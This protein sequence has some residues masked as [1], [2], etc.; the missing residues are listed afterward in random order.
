M[1]KQTI[2]T[3]I[4]RL[5][6]SADGKPPGQERF[7]KTTGIRMSEW[8]P[9]LWLRWGEALQE[10]GFSPN[11]LTA[12]FDERRVLECYIGLIRQLGRVPV[13]GELKRQAKSD[14]TFPSHNVFSRFGGKGELLEKVR[15]FCS[16]DSGFDDVVAVLPPRPSEPA[17]SLRT[18]AS[19]Q[20]YVYMMRSG[21]RYKIGF[22]NSPVRRHRE[23]KLE[24]P[25]PTQLVHS[26][27]TD[28]PKGIEAYWHRRFEAKR[29]RDTE[30]FELDATDVASFKRRRYQ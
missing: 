8:Y 4:R 17:E 11:R 10:A 12:A 9:H 30:F 27:E 2:L 18:R 23:V 6:E 28:D 3:E 5:A 15:E 1:D 19:I 26:I 13:A 25:D 21:R 14:P 29:I 16:A 20:G 24:L 22:T 7:A